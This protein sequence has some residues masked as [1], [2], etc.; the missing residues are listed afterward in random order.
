[1]ETSSETRAPNVIV[2]G[3]GGASGSG[4]STLA[5][6]LEAALS[7]SSEV[8]VLKMDKYF[9]HMKIS[10]DLGTFCTT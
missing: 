2:I 3:I 4:K 9:D 10:R 5:L 1:M 7:I 6:N 8:R